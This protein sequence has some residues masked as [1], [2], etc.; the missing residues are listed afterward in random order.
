MPVYKKY[1]KWNG[2]CWMVED[3]DGL[4]QELSKQEVGLYINYYFYDNDH[5]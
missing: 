2:K 1:G 4:L 3:I 5:E